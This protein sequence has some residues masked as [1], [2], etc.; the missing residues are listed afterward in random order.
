[1][2]RNAIG[3]DTTKMA[4]VVGFIDQEVGRIDALVKDLDGR[5]KEVYWEG[6][7]ADHFKHQGWSDAQA[8]LKRAKDTLVGAKEVL[9]RNIKSQNDASRRGR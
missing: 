4:K 2:A 6:D 3:M 5:V 9:Q 8:K 7:D 1:M